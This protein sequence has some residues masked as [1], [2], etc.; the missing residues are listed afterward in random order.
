MLFTFPSRYWFA[1]GLS[2]VFSLARWSR[3]FHAGF[4]VPR[5]TQDTATP[6]PASGTGLSPPMVGL[7][8]P[9]PSPSR[10]DTA[11]L[12]P[13]RRLD[14]AGLG[15]SPFAR[16]YLGNKHFVLFSC[17]YLDV[18]VPRVRPGAWRRWR[19]RSRRVAPFGCLGIDARLPLPQAFRSLPRPS[20]P[21]RA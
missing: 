12:L 13:R 18:S 9:F 20:S 19:D 3:R 21:P 1:I 4:L 11:V 5:A 14:A 16:R 8:R 7:S 17:G 10:Y 15:S 6:G 2:G